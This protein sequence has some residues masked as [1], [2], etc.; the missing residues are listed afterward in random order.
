[1]KERRKNFMVCKKLSSIIIMCTFTIP[2]QVFHEETGENYPESRNFLSLSTEYLFASLGF[3]AFIMREREIK[4]ISL[5][6]KSSKNEE[7]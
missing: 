2:F 7:N 1:M 4:S 6:K 5:M 3:I